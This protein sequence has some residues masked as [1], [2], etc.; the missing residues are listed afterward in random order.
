MKRLSFLFIL[1][2]LYMG[3][4]FGAVRSGQQTFA[5]Y[6]PMKAAGDV[7]TLTCVTYEADNSDDGTSV[8]MYTEGYDE[9]DDSN[10]GQTVWQ[11]RLQFKNDQLEDN[12]EYT[13]D[14]LIDYQSFIREDG[15]WDFNTF[16]TLSY[17]QWSEDNGAFHV[18]ASA[19]TSNGKE[20]KITYD[21]GST[22]PSGDVR[23]LT[24][25]NN[26]VS[27][28]D[29]IQMD[30]TF[31]FCGKNSQAEI[32][33]T[34][35]SDQIE[36]TYG[37]SDFLP[38]Y[39][40]I[41]LFDEDG[42]ATLITFTDIHAE[43]AA[44]EGKTK[45]YT[46]DFTGVTEE[47]TV[48]K[49][50]LTYIPSDLEYED[51][52][53]IEANN[54]EVLNF[55]EKEGLIIFNGSN[56][57]YGVSLTVNTN[58]LY[59]TWDFEN[60]DGFWSDVSVY[61]ED[62][63]AVAMYQI[64]NG[65]ITY[66]KDENGDQLLSGWVLGSDKVKYNL[67]IYYKLPSPTFTKDLTVTDARVKDL[68]GDHEKSLRIQGTTSDKKYFLSVKINTSS[69]TGSFNID[70][71]NKDYTFVDLLNDNGYEDV[72][73]TLLD[74]DVTV[75]LADG[76]YT[77]TGTLLMQFGEEVPQFAINMTGKLQIGLDY[78]I[79]SEGIKAVL[80]AVQTK[81]YNDANGH[82]ALLVA[83]ED[84]SSPEHM[85]YLQFMFGDS[86]PDIII[87]EGVYEINDSYDDFTV[88]ACPGLSGGKVG[89]SFMCN[90]SNGQ[91]EIPMW[92]LRS[93]TVTVSKNDNN[94]IYVAVEAKN[95]YGQ[96]I[97]IT[98][99]TDPSGIETV[100]QEAPSATKRIVNGELII[101]RNG[102]SYSVLGIKK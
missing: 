44:I 40:G 34:I 13:V 84:M 41:Y 31:Q 63:I 99:G 50:F 68:T 94:E 64:K 24:F 4:A 20:W 42:K 3:I 43:V 80:P 22:T 69:P 78:D 45:A 14:D 100:R 89:P 6:A 32:R 82:Y 17:K 74:G 60:L 1:L 30:E 92:F 2:S 73:Y 54:L 37:W 10:N 27:M 66:A 19:T 59:G 23:V 61:D 88:V 11:V 55:I 87:P 90:L 67:N 49:T 51:E 39:S 36:G 70:N 33:I 21:K 28:T 102:E 72:S 16:Q 53:E 58:T 9:D 47:G 18:R 15:T 76:T 86:D 98:A 85:L 7:T 57:K 25:S 5:A 95:S 26:E 38:L 91:A 62:G 35:S 96:P 101:E 81:E 75:S 93:G 97:Q 52:I 8:V 77:V 29:Y 48:Y 83:T 65:Q 56:D 71:L 46:C 79:E 12:H